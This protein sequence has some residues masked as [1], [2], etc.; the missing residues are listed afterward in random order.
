MG[1][2]REGNLREVKKNL[3]IL[4]IM[5]FY[6]IIFKIVHNYYET[7]IFW[8]GKCQRFMIRMC[9]LQLAERSQKKY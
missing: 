5:I 8:R 2:V 7:L 3:Y 6:F 9:N 1:H 4:L